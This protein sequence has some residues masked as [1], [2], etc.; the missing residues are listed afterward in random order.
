MH[1]QALAA[2]CSLPFF[3]L[4]LSLSF[5]PS[6]FSSPR[7]TLVHQTISVI[8]SVFYVKPSKVPSFKTLETQ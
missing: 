5:L 8:I 3:F 7:P 6:D 4:S 1:R 2:A